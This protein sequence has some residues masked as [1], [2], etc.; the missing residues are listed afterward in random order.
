MIAER[1]I[2]KFSQILDTQMNTILTHIAYLRDYSAVQK[3]AMKK[4]SYV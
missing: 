1:D 4:K 3:Q 2:T